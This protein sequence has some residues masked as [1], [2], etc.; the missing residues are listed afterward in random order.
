MIID[1][2]CH[3]WEKD[4]VGGEMA[5]LMELGKEDPIAAAMI[6]GAESFA[7]GMEARRLET[8]DASIEILREIKLMGKEATM[9]MVETIKGE[10]NIEERMHRLAGHF[11]TLMEP[12]NDATQILVE[13][14]KPSQQAGWG[15]PTPE[16]L[17]QE[18][19]QRFGGPRRD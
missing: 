10:G 12:L 1:A 8:A 15:E 14:I 4:I 3:I 13:L 5:K 9:A 6:S 17:E 11:R 19:G 16:M 18:M 2:H 7:V